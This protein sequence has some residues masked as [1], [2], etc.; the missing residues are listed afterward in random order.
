[1]RPVHIL[2]LLALLAGLIPATAVG[3]QEYYSHIRPLI[4]QNCLGCHS[5]AGVA[6]SMEDPEEAYEKRRMIGRMIVQRRMPPWLAE[7]GHQ[8]YRGDPSLAPEEIEAVARWV[9]AGYPKGQP[10]PDPESSAPPSSF[11][12][13]LSLDVLPD[14]S[15]TP[16]QDRSDDYRCFV[17]DWPEEGPRYITGFRAAPG[18]L[19]VSHHTVVF[20][21]MPEV[22]GRFRELEDAEEGPGYPCFG[23]AVPDRLGRRADRDAYEARY[24]DGLRELS[25][26]NFW[27]AHWAPGMDG[28][29]FPDETGIRMEPGSALVAQMHYYTRDAP[30]QS[31][32]D[33]R[34]EFALADRVERPAFHLAQ[35]RNDW[36]N[37][38]EN[39]TLVVPPGKRATYAVRNDLGTL[40]PYVSRVTGVDTARIEGLEVHSANLHMHAYGHSG[41]ITL[42][43]RNGRRETLLAIPRWDL[44]WQRDFAF[45][46]PKVFSREQL[47]GTILEV[48]CTYRNP[49]TTP[50]FGGFG[51]YDEMCFN[52]SYIAV[53][54]GPEEVTAR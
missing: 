37:A 13:D 46:Q 8:E 54:V 40:I 50:V 32:R 22:A 23:G 10:R 19:E 45:R 49:E 12:A 39:G 30:G 17:M 4:Q 15:Y 36:L 14:G 7:P 16:D 35:T 6:T 5:E 26:G 28:H 1:M 51:S 27:L 3:A 11:R 21:V 52:F 53:Q 18:N 38:E 34:L 42:T 33:S 41:E 9:E 24:P 48:E 25:R 44:D 29:T 47:D 31:D 2:A 20:A 43:E